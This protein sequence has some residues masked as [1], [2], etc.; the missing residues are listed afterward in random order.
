MISGGKSQKLG[1]ENALVCPV[2]PKAFSL[3]YTLKQHHLIQS[4]TPSSVK[5]GEVFYTGPTVTRLWH[6]QS[7]MGPPLAVRKMCLMQMIAQWLRET[8]L[9]LWVEYCGNKLIVQMWT[10]AS[11]TH[12]DCLLFNNL[13]IHLH[14]HN[15]PKQLESG[16]E[17]TQIFPA[18]AN[19]RMHLGLQNNFETPMS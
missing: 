7:Y 13:W 18:M 9:M 14:T 5:S 3:P 19:M 11:I 8:F 10:S 4:D 17:S 15:R 2:C 16:S 12:N 1:T 6:W